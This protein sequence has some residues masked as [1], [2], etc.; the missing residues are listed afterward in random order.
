MGRRIVA[1]V[2]LPHTPA[3][4]AVLGATA[5]FGLLASGGEPP[6]GRFG[7]LLLGMLGGQVAIGALNEWHDREA[8]ALSQPEKPIPSGLVSPDGALRMLAGGVLLLVCAGAAL[9]GWSFVLLLAGTGCGLVY[10]LW[11]KATP[12]SWL[13][14]LLALPLLPTWVWL[15]LD[16]FEPRLLLLYPLGALLVVAVHL[17]QTLPDIAGDR[18]R[19]ERGLAA[20]LGREWALRVLWLA[21]FGSVAVVAG[22][23]LVFGRRPGIGVGAALPAGVLLLAAFLLQR[24]APER[25][26]PRLFEILALCAIVLA[27]GWVVAIV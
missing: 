6:A 1:Y 14:Y 8:D 22:G 13:P 15:T 3:I 23:A 17:A 27:A 26:E 19:G 18:A 4:V 2:M 21:G 24:R 25:V 11:L 16:G 10:D 7:L 5:L 9:G 20:L 12:F